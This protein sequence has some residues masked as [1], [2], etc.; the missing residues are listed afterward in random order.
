MSDLR[1]LALSR[2]HF[3]GALAGG[4]ATSVATA[5][6]ARALL[7]QNA[8][9]PAEPAAQGSDPAAYQGAANVPMD[10]GAYKSVRRPPKPG[11][12]PSMTAAE[13]DELEHH[14]HCQ[15]GCVLDIYTC[16]TTDFSCGVSPAMHRDVMSLVQGG[17]SADEII[18][19]F[20]GAYGERVLMSPVKEGFNWA[21]YVTPFAAIGAGAVVVATLIRKWGRRAEAR[22]RPVEVRPLQVDASPDELARIAAAVRE[23]AR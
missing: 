16:R 12:T 21:G 2:R 8:P 23:D 6:G 19:A 7:A 20:R 5:A 13:R 15:C 1:D 11:A 14:I 17:Y 10:E 9:A 4:F 3:L 22:V 18:A